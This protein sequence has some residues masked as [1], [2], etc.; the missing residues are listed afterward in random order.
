M[1]ILEILRARRVS[2]FVFLGQKPGRPIS[3]HA[4]E[5]LVPAGATMHGFRSSFR[6]FCGEETSFAREDVEQCLA[7]A[8]GNA[9]E[10][11][12][13]RGDALEKRRQ[14]MTASSDFLDGHAA[15]NVVQIG[16]RKG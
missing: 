9:V 6:D 15:A 14:I 2:N 12:Y 13:R 7:H 3:A 10:R 16:S 5:K 11:A 4:L 8:V 1:A